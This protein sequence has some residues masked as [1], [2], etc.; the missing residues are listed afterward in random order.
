MTLPDSSG[1]DPDTERCSRYLDGDLPPAARTAF[2]ADLASDRGLMLQLAELQLASA[3]VATP[4]EIGGHELEAILKSIVGAR[5]EDPAGRVSAG[6][7]SNVVVGETLDGVDNVTALP[8]WSTRR[9]ARATPPRRWLTPLLQW[10][11]AAAVIG[12]IA[13]AALSANPGGDDAGGEAESASADT[14]TLPFGAQRD[15]VVT[16]QGAVNDRLDDAAEHGAANYAVDEAVKSSAVDLNPTT[17]AAALATTSRDASP[18]GVV[19][20]PLGNFLD[21]G[22]L[23]AHIRGLLPTAPGSAEANQLPGST[24]LN[25]S[26][27]DCLADLTGTAMVAGRSVQWGWRSTAASGDLRLVIV[28]AQSC[29]ILLNEPA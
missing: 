11:A 29:A 7:R 12:V 5:V 10:S 21:V 26:A 4:V 18:R 8:A 25:G 1:P 15:A 19:S 20:E 9:R 28:D 3:W 6:T 17:S 23:A 27:G 22:V 24:T 14:T 2:E 16:K 13:V